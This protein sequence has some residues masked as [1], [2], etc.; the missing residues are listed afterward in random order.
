MIS[1][2]DLVTLSKSEDPPKKKSQLSQ[3]RISA[4][5]KATFLWTKALLNYL[6]K[7][8]GHGQRD[9]LPNVSIALNALYLSWELSTTKTKLSDLE[10]LKDFN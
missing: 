9:R 3:Q 8:Q 2:V 6:V 1:E 7:D 5:R 10:E 4:K